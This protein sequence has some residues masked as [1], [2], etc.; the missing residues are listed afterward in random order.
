MLELD[1]MRRQ[2]EKRAEELE[3][4]AAAIAGDRAAL[5]TEYSAKIAEMTAAKGRL[6]AQVREGV[7]A[8]VCGGRAWGGAA[9][10]R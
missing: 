7:D 9:S 8:R 6:E 4:A 10:E 2:L 5:K 3:A 1:A